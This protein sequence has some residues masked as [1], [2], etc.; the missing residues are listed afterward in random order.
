MTKK[1][2]NSI[3]K[4]LKKLQRI[5][6]ATGEVAHSLMPLGL[7]FLFLVIVFFSVQI[8]TGGVNNGMVIVVAGVL[9]A[10]MALNIGAN[11]VANNVSPAVGSKALTMA[12]ALILAAIFEAGGAIIAGGEVVSTIKNGIVDQSLITEN[13]T[14]ILLM[15]SALLAAAL[16]LNLAT[17]LGAPVS[18]THSIVGGVMGAGIVAVGI[19]AVSWP[20]MGK[21]A[22]SWVISP[23]MGGVIAAGLF[24]FIKHVILSKSDMLQASKRWVPVLVSVMVSSFTMYLM[25][26]GLKNIW[27]PA[28]DTI[29]ITGLVILLVLPVLLNPFVS[30]Q[31][32]NLE[33]KAKGVNRLF[34]IPLIISAALLSFAHGSN[35]VANAIGPLAAIVSSATEGAI[36]SKVGIPHWVMLIGALGISLGL[37]L[38]GPKIIHTVGKKITKLDQVRAF[39]IAL[40]AAVTV[41]VASTLGLPVSS[42]HITVG[43]VFGVGLYREFSNHKKRK[44]AQALSARKLEKRKLV[45]RRYLLSIAAAWVITVPCAALLAS[46]IYMLL[47]YLQVSAFIS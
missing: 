29:W 22:A 7:G 45:R 17:Y 15:L 19:A 36:S 21:I 47:D 4:D 25:M 35:D 42:T 34:T 3:H 8:L 11:D 2:S 31:T 40:S 32:K 33:N 13:S 24:K 14:F 16:W 23:V 10:Y 27:K 37:L 44:K 1:T 26:K 46:L 28:P 9:G 41:I 39:C 5:E 20:T 12:G 6:K 38:F 18:T 30:S 43:G